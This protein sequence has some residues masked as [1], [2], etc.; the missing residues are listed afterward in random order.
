MI[1]KVAI[2][3]S[4]FLAYQLSIISRTLSQGKVLDSH[5]FNYIGVKNILKDQFALL[6]QCYQKQQFEMGI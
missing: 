5:K 6:P 2:R 3:I 1:F 4:Y